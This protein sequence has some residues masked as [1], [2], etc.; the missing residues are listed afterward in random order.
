MMTE[1]TVAMLERWQETVAG[2]TP[3]DI[4]LEMMR[5]TLCIVGLALF[6]LDLSNEMDTVGR[7]FTTVAP[8]ITRYSLL[9]FPPLWVPTSG[10]RRLLAGLNTLNCIGNHFA[11]ME[12]QLVLAT[13][14]QR[15]S[16]HLVSG[17]PVE[18]QVLLTMRP[19][20]G[21]PMTLRPR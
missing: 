12:A 19:R 2:D 9:P 7:A 18:I 16:L 8:L 20:S 14:A 15:Y 21:L 6:S 4:S 13:V 17:H 10:N 11:M 3:L 5:L 1:A